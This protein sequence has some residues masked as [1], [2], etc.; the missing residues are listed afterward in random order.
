[1]PRQSDVA[2]ISFIHSL[3]VNCMTGTS[4]RWN[5]WWASTC[6]CQPTSSG[7]SPA[8]TEPTIWLQFYSSWQVSQFY[9][10]P[11][12]A[13]SW[14]KKCR[15]F[16]LLR[17]RTSRTRTRWTRRRH[18][19]ASWSFRLRPI[20]LTT[21]NLREICCNL[22]ASKPASAPPAVLTKRITLHS[23][24]TS[25]SKSGRPSTPR[26][27]LTDCW[28]GFNGASRIRVMP[29]RITLQPSWTMRPPARKRPHTFNVFGM[30]T[31]PS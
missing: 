31:P 30:T 7:P 28:N 25:T 12:R 5:A 20:E 14:L 29:R 26:T 3:T 6:P 8:A 21:T 16:E 11:W 2:S 10:F 22:L 24:L 1:M 18:W 13:S 17:P 23:W 15:K 4:D 19:T 27:R 9:P